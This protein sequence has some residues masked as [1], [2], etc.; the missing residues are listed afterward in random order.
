MDQSKER[1][2]MALIHS[3]LRTSFRVMA[4]ATLFITL[5][6]PMELGGSK[7]LIVDLERE[8]SSTEPVPLTPHPRVTEPL[9]R[10][11]FASPLLGL[12]T[13]G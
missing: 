6:P 8:L 7:G 10:T 2:E 4:T 13:L 12:V 11:H 5:L 9:T 3:P 1:N